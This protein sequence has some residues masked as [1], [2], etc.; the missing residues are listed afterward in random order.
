MSSKAQSASNPSAGRYVVLISVAAALGGF[1]FGY[2]TAV[3]N[4]TVGIDLL[5]YDSLG[6]GVVSYHCHRQSVNFQGLDY[7]F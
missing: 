3:V 4:G 1:L 2:D 5:A 6:D 7:L